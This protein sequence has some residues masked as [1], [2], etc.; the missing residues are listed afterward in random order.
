MFISSLVDLMNSH[1][2]CCCC[3]DDDRRVAAD[4]LPADDDFFLTF[5][6]MM[7]LERNSRIIALTR[8]QETGS[9]E[10]EAHDSG[11]ENTGE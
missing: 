11:A 5:K 3:K 7:L 2:P 10:L 4:V 6:S 8:W 1:P 9:R